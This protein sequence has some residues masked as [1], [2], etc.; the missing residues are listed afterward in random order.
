MI[1]PSELPRAGEPGMGEAPARECLRLRTLLGDHPGTT[2][3]KDGTLSSSIVALDFVP[4]KVPNRRFKAVVR[5]NT[6]DVAELAIA[7]FLQAKALG[8]PLV[9]LPATVLARHQHSRLVFNPERGALTPQMLEGRRVGIRSWSVTTSMW[10][11]GILA[12]DYG[13]ELDRV[14]WVTFEDAHVAEFSDPPHVERAGPD[15]DLLAMLHDGEVD[16]GVLGA[17]PPEGSPL[18]P[19]LANPDNL[20][21]D[22]CTRNGAVPLNHLVVVNGALCERAPAAVREVYRLLLEGRR[23]L[24]PVG[25]PV[26][27]SADSSFDLL[28][29]GLDAL[30]PSLQI[31]IDYCQSQGL[32]ARPLAVDD[33]FDDLTRT[34]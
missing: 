17:P 6:F 5:E 2:A 3:L 20:G 24:G 27:D 11:R 22:W 14:N 19:L 10:V 13:V 29:F 33:L 23:R 28:P 21:R 16:A 25:K 34:L 18:R 12:A 1:A 26:P 30:R 4:E 8:S 15:K 31:A 7:T 32:L 9:L